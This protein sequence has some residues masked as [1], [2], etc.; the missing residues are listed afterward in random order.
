ML[1]EYCQAMHGQKIDQIVSPVPIDSSFLPSNRRIVD[2]RCGGSFALALDGASFFLRV[3]C[4]RE[5][6]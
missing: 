3:S 2:Y 5:K 1:Q 4:A 6:G